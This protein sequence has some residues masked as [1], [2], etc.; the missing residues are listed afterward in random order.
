MYNCI[1]SEI[2]SHELDDN[3]FKFTHNLVNHEALS[4][5]NLSKV[6]PKLPKK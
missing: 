6:L 1:T 5:E 2:N 4:L 3:P